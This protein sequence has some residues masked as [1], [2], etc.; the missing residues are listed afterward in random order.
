M[1]RN[2]YT[3][4]LFFRSSRISC[5]SDV[6]ES[7]SSETQEAVL[8]RSASTGMVN[9]DREAWQRVAEGTLNLV[10]LRYNPKR[11]SRN[12]SVLNHSQQQESVIVNSI[13]P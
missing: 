2:L 4:T 8:G 3:Y 10:L 12:T 5:E 6:T 13:I 1:L 7:H 9:V 11:N